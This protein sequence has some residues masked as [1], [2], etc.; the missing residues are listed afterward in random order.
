M[1]K[2][3]DEPKFTIPV[4]IKVPV[5][6]GHKDETLTA[7]FKVLKTETLAGFN[8]TTEQGTRD[9]LDAAV[10]RLDDLADGDGKPLEFNDEVKAAVLSLPYARA[11]L[12]NAYYAAVTKVARGN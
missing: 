5:D 2:I 3:I 12:A 6:G 8:M 4:T 10:D 7:T 9:M 11:G 1:F